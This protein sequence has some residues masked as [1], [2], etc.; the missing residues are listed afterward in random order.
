[1]VN[2]LSGY[3]NPFDSTQTYGIAPQGKGNDV[4]A[5]IHDDSDP[6]LLA[7]IAAEPMP[8]QLPV[9]APSLCPH[10]PPTMAGG[11]K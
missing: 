2:G 8:R 3:S 10:R 4:P 9:T 11:C 1:M 7:L 6:N 5:L